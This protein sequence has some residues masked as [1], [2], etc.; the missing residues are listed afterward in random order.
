MNTPREVFENFIE[1][2][3]DRTLL[4]KTVAPRPLDD[5]EALLGLFPA[6]YREF[7]LSYGWVQVE[8]HQL[9][10]ALQAVKSSLPPI[11][12]FTS[13]LDLWTV[14]R[15]SRPLGLSSGLVPVAS[16]GRGNYF[17]MRPIRGAVDRKADGPVWYFDH[18]ERTNVKVAPG[19]V[20]WLGAYASLACLARD[21]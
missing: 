18:E 15:E 1:K 12:E 17:C 5:A 6:S 20:P 11:Y 10:A 2:W 21:A 4:P 9:V 3:V 16:D 14:A 13:P 19:F 7:L 8:A